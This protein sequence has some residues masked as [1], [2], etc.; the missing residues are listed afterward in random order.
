MEM[1]LTKGSVLGNILKFSLPYF[2]AYFL[3]TLYG[4]ADLF[5]IGQYAAVDSTTAVSIGSQV[6]HFITVMIVG[7]AMGTTVMIS[8]N[9]GA[10]NRKKASLVIGNSVVIF[11]GMAVVLTAVLLCLIEPIITG[12]STPTEAVSGTRNYLMICFIGI[13]MIT[14]YNVISS[15]FRGM[16]DS[17]SPMYFIAIACAVNILLDYWFIGGLQMG[18]S[19][20]AL[21]T[22]LA[23]MFSVLVSLTVIIKRKVL[24]IQKSDFQPNKILI[25]TILKTGVPI[26]LQD[27]FIQVAFLV[28]TVIANMR[29]LTDAAAVGIVEKMIGMMFL[30]PSSMLSSVSATA[31]QNLGA[32]EQKRAEKTLRYALLITVVYGF[33][34]GLIVQ[35][36]AGQL[37][38]LFTDDAAVI[39]A[40]GQYFRSY[41]WDCVFAGVHF[42]FSGYFCACEKAIYSFIH[43]IVSIILIRI[44]FSYVL[45]VQFPTTLYP[46]GLAAPMGSILSALICVG[47]F[48]FLIKRPK[49]QS[50]GQ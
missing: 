44:P 33:L 19:G 4:M 13:P 23:Q 41:A 39:H 36:T 47:M 22:V 28:I 48:V 9:I 14:A 21:G 3:Q 49:K 30:V 32:G 24:P 2:V 43:N 40:G 11:S 37:V 45:S 38:G 34:A 50:F 46:M 26:A 17:K 31:A 27:G 15:I 6:M 42:C 35:F 8:R 16:G 18:A 20:A 25:G 29:G 12:M 5:I 1:N 10:G 7:L